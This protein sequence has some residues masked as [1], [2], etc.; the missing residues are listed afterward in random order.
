MFSFIIGLF[1][2]LVVGYNFSSKIDKF[3]DKVKEEL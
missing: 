3:L 1:V 2:G